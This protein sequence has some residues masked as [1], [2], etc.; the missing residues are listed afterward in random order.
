LHQSQKI[1]KLELQ[2]EDERETKEKWRG[3]YLEIA[4][5]TE[6]AVRNFSKGTLKL[7]PI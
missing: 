6:R 4:K 2:L 7:S 5:E 1:S 3:R